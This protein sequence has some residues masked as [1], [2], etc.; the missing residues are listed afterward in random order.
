[1]SLELSN[2]DVLWLAQKMGESRN[3]LWCNW[4]PPLASNCCQMS[5]CARSVVFC[6]H[7]TYI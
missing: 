7:K 1:M 6:K 5:L 2:G 4:H 3:I